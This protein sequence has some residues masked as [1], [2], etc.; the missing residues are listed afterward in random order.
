MRKLLFLLAFSATVFAQDA[1]LKVEIK[2]PNSDSIVI[3][4]YATRKPEVFKAIKPG[5]FAANL[6]AQ[7]GFY[8]F[9]DGNEQTM[10]YLRPGFDLAMKLDTKMFDE[11]IVFSGK[12][13]VENNFLA[14]KALDDEQMQEG[15]GAKT[16]DTE[17]LGKQLRQREETYAKTLAGSGFDPEFRK[18]M[19]TQIAAETKGIQ[20]EFEA[21]KQ[22]NAT[23]ASLKGNPSPTF[24]YEN[25]KGGTTQL[26]DLRGKYV[27]IDVWATWCGP[28]RQ[29]IPFLQKVEEKYHGKNIAF[30]SIS[31]DVAKDH[32]KWRK[33][34][35][36][37]NLGGIQLFADKNWESDFLVAYGIDSIP[38]F[39][40]IDPNGNVVDPDA[41]RPSDP[42]LVKQLD[43]L[44]R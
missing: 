41:A 20:A 44:L 3:T 13:A 24:D 22:K 15:F 16:P 38:R 25:H 28:C 21:M 2:N 34:V 32:E 17:A 12:G 8:R 37:K 31:A 40:L 1:K 6:A 4:S 43:G 14:K 23:L 19:L 7:P 33:F 9:F 36:D 11:T 26:E 42:A 18:L 39:I 35:T 5:Q 27:Y 30:V 29:E 10:L